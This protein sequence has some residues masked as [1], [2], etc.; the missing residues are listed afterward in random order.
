MNKLIFSGFMC[1]VLSSLVFAESSKIT[2]VDLD[3]KTT[4]IIKA[5]I[6]RDDLVYYMDATA[7]ICWVSQ[8]MGSS[9]AVSTF[10]C[11]KLVKHPKLEKYV[12]DC[13]SPKKEETIKKDESPLKAEE[14]KPESEAKQPEAAIPFVVEEK[15]KEPANNVKK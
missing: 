3:V 7:C 15:S 14:V 10:D 8:S 11:S 2:K 13:N 1:C 12:A 4:H 5:D 6:G 9:F